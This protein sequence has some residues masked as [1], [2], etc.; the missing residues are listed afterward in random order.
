VAQ[1]AHAQSPDPRTETA[2]PTPSSYGL[3]LRLASSNQL[4]I[5]FEG[6]SRSARNCHRKG[7]V[8]HSSIA[9][10]ELS[11]APSPALDPLPWMPCSSC[12]WRSNLAVLVAMRLETPSIP[13]RM[14]SQILAAHH[15]CAGVNRGP[16]SCAEL[17]RPASSWC[18][19][20]RP[21]KLHFHARTCISERIDRSA[22]LTFRFSSQLRETGTA[23]TST[24]HLHIIPRHFFPLETPRLHY[25]CIASTPCP[26]TSSYHFLTSSPCTS[27]WRAGASFP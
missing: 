19:G 17:C 22:R 12:L 23:C 6:K 16:V 24:L 4:I 21:G 11:K 14:S 15:G 2:S 26:S 9:W 27:E 18:P 20:S 10:Q 8:N 13:R 1:D 3:N 7:Q 5:S 25:F